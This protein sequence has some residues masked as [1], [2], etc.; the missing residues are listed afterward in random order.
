[1][2]IKEKLYWGYYKC[3]GCGRRNENKYEY[4]SCGVKKGKT[5]N[6]YNQGEAK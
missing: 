4:C 1:V 3:K 2:L 5:K 6:I